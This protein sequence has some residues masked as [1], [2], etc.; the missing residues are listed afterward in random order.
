MNTSYCHKGNSTWQNMRIIVTSL[1]QSWGREE[2]VVEKSPIEILIPT[3]PKTIDTYKYLKLIDENKKY[4]NFGPLNEELIM[5][6]STRTGIS[7][8]RISTASNAT[9][10]LQGAIATAKQGA[11]NS[12]ELPSWTFTATPSALLA[13]NKPAHF[14]DVDK[15]QRVVPTNGVVNL[16]DVLPFGSNLNLERLQIYKESLENVVVDAAASFDSIKD[17]NLDVPFKVAIIVSLHATKLLPA[18]EGAIFITNDEIWAKDFKAWTNFGMN[19]E[20]ISNS[21]GTNAKLSEFAAAVALSSLDNWSETRQRYLEI[22]ANAIAISSR[23]GL[24]VSEAMRI[25]MISPYW[26]LQCE[27]KK[28][29]RIISDQFNLASIATRDWWG[30]GCHT[31]PA[32]KDIMVTDLSNTKFFAETTTAIPFHLGLSRNDFARIEATLQTSVD[33]FKKIC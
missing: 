2:L 6:I 27:N 23:L 3:V 9:L 18:G 20:R 24:Q 8:Q 5:R 7:P 25:G 31:M 14:V 11:S 19:E 10:G 4:S 12:W 32:Y 13:T 22:S 15:L 21:L 17:L 26:I 29:K 33:L 16:I 1:Y 28:L 30:N